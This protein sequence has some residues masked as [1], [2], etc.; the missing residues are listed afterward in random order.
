[1]K[2]NIISAMMTIFLIVG[3]KSPNND[4]VNAPVSKEPDHELVISG[5][6]ALSPLMEIWASEFTKIHP[7]IHIKVLGNGSGAGLADMISGRNNIAMI[8]RKLTPDE[9][10]KGFWFADVSREGVVPVISD[11]NPTLGL[12][13]KQGIQRK[14]LSQ[15]FSSENKTYWG[16]IV[17]SDNKSPVHIYTRADQ[18]GAADIWAQYL[19]LKSDNLNGAKMVG[20]TGIIKALLKDPYGLSYCNAH[21]AY[22]TK[23]DKQLDGLRVLPIDFN[24][25]GKID[26]KEDFFEKIS[27]LHRAAYL[28]AYPTHLCRELTLVC[29]NKPTDKV[30]IEFVKWILTDGQEIAVKNGY[31]EIRHCVREEALKG[32]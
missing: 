27:K 3:C 5:A 12:L 2:S 4:V 20:D 23:A 17:G 19:D 22:D 14:T 10:S 26:Q 7:S 21:Y 28:G 1:M 24:N 18:S 16:T 31:C 13:L 9:E 29:K 6:Y 15:L 8:S 32:L 11:K 25:N 30:I